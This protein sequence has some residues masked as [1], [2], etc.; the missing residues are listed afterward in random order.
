MSWSLLD[1]SRSSCAITRNIVPTSSSLYVMLC[2]TGPQRVWCEH[3]QACMDAVR[4]LELRVKDD[5]DKLA[6]RRASL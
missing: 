5:P 6:D 4:W 3:G 1:Y 2:S